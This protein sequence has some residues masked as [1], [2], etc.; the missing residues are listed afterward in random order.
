MSTH[1]E[2]IEK[3]NTLVDSLD[4]HIE[5][6]KKNGTPI[7]STKILLSMLSNAVIHLLEEDEKRSQS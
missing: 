7:D 2:Y 1:K 3:L 5:L 6:M 4:T